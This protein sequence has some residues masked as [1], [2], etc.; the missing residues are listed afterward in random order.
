MTDTA[1]FEAR[2]TGEFAFVGSP[3]P[4]PHGGSRSLAG[5]IRAAMA[6]VQAGLDSVGCALTDVV[7]ATCYLAEDAYRGDFW[8][9]W[10]EWFPA[11]A[12]PVRL[13]L[14]AAL[15]YQD[16]VRLEVLAERA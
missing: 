16:R 1:A 2:S 5:E 3:V 12:H 9:A 15:P 6:G 13:T 4:E 8:A 10:A 7:K 11:D 14:V